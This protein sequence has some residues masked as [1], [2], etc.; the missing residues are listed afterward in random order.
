MEGLFIQTLKLESLIEKNIN[1]IKTDPILKK[2]F[3][4]LL[5]NNRADL[6]Q[7]LDTVY[8]N[9]KIPTLFLIDSAN[10]FQFENFVQNISFSN[11]T[12]QPGQ[13]NIQVNN[14]STN[15]ELYSNQRNTEGISSNSNLNFSSGENTNNPVALNLIN[16]R[17]VSNNQLNGNKNNISGGIPI[18]V[19]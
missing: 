19:V 7:K 14:N 1:K 16:Y 5:N 18:K 17:E 4:T 6:V 8:Q 15:F 2:N 12:N 13:S 3:L 10:E 9:S 11:T